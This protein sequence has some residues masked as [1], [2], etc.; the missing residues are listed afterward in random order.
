LAAASSPVPQLGPRATWSF[1]R[2]IRTAADDL[3]PNRSA[4]GLPAIQDQLPKATG[5]LRAGGFLVV[6]EEIRRAA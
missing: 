5:A 6:P 3:S 1:V 2:P 4:N